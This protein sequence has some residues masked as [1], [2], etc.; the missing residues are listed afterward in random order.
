MTLKLQDQLD[1]TKLHEQA[2]Q[3]GVSSV[4]LAQRFVIERL[5]AAERSA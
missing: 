3:Q 1:L 2:E 4:T 5:E